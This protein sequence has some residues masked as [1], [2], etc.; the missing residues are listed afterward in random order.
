MLAFPIPDFLVQASLLEFPSDFSF[1]PCN[2]DTRKNVSW[3]LWDYIAV[4]TIR[5][6]VQFKALQVQTGILHDPWSTGRE[7][8]WFHH[9]LS[10]RSDCE[11]SYRF[12]HLYKDLPLCTF[13]VCDK[14]GMNSKACTYVHH[15]FYPKIYIDIFREIINDAWYKAGVKAADILEAVLLYT[16]L[17]LWALN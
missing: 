7:C 2:L 11:R 8:K 15:L 4:R 6:C 5:W 17:N 14:G 9:T 1:L 13:F 12:C 10:L 16:A 3:I